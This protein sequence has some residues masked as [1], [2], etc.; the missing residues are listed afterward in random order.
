M[1]SRKYRYFDQDSAEY[2]RN[3]E[4]RLKETFS[5]SADLRTGKC[6]HSVPSRELMA[7]GTGAD[8]ERND[9]LP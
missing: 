5:V 2:A 8:L 3:S 9:D 7:Q 4:T 1:L 6:N